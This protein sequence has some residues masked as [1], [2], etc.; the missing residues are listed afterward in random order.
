MSIF[1]LSPGVSKLIFWLLPIV[2]F[3]IF[4]PVG[5]TETDQGFIQGLSYRI[6]EGGRK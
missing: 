4:G 1:R 5:F 2:Y 3:L 6:L